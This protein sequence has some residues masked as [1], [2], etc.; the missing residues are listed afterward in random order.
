[1]ELLF[2]KRVDKGASAD[3]AGG[4]P[5][6]AWEVLA[7]PSARLKPGQAVF[8]EG[9]EELTLSEPLGDGRWIAVREGTPGV[10]QLLRRHGVMPLPPYIHTPLADPDDYQ[11]VYATVPGSAAAPTAGLHFTTEIL[12]ALRSEGVQV[13]GVTLHVGVDTFRPVTEQVV[14]RHAI[15]TETYAVDA[16]ALARLDAARREGRRLVAVG[17]TSVRVLETL[18]QASTPAGAASAAPSGDT[19]VFITPG[20]RFRAVDALLTNFHLPRTSLLAL[21]MAFGGAD[22]IRHVY[23]SAVAER[24]RFFSFGDAMFLV[25]PADAGDRAEVRR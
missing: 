24:Y 4:G 8:M 13:E 21:V 14:E 7:R 6:E 15:H 17:T 3:T 11:T 16:A 1:V 10:A 18:Y 5:L 23:R 19:A 20:H 2:L 9:G 25:R 22:F 12:G